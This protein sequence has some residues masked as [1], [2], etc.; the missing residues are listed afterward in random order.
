MSGIQGPNWARLTLADVSMHTPGW[1]ATNTYGLFDP[2][3]KRRQL[4]SIPDVDG[5]KSYPHRRTFRVYDLE[6][7]VI[8]EYDLNGTP[9][10]DPEEGCEANLDYLRD[11]VY[12]AEE[13]DDGTIAGDLS[14]RDGQVIEARVQVNDMQ[15][16]DRRATWAQLVF[17]LV[18]PQGAFYLEGS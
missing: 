1:W 16:I 10:D 8:G 2:A 5:G 14:R 11:N 15:T 9:Y 17:E 13:D 6:V 3:P 18:I 7:P 4:R 12:L